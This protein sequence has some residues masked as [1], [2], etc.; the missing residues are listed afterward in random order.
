MTLLNDSSHAAKCDANELVKERCKPKTIFSDLN[1]SEVDLK[2][3]R[4]SYLPREAEANRLRIMFKIN[5]W[6]L[7]TGH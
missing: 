7:A 2:T 6:R 1:Y 5:S 3:W 4:E